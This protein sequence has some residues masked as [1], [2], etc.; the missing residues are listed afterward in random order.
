MF[1]FNSLTC[2]HT[3]NQQKQKLHTVDEIS[4]SDFV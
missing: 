3:I 2:A 4:T 1:V